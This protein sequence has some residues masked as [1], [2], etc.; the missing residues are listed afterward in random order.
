MPKKAI[1]LGVEPSQYHTHHF[2]TEKQKVKQG[3]SESF[4]RLMTYGISSTSVLGNAN[5]GYLHIAV[6]P[7]IPKTSEHSPVSLIDAECSIWSLVR[8]ISARL[9]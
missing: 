5:N 4:G 1:I 9:I 3:K 2:K 8:W 6:S 7:L